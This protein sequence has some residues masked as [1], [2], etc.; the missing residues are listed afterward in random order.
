MTLSDVLSNAK[1]IILWTAIVIF[2]VAA[3]SLVSYYKG[4]HDRADKDR[5][6]LQTAPRDTV[7]RIDTLRLPSPPPQTKP[8]KPAVITDTTMDVVDALLA[9]LNQTE[10]QRDSA[11]EELY[12]IASPLEADFEDSVAVES[13]RVDPI[14]RV[15]RREIHYKPLAVSAADIST[16]VIPPASFWDDAPKYG[17]GALVGG[18]AVAI[19][20]SLTH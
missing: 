8:A 2:L 15:I 13:I 9:L 18:A 1:S 20:Y 11:R 17:L 7:W 14:E 6:A 10:A 3:V 12:R 19:I 4:D 16:V 5:I